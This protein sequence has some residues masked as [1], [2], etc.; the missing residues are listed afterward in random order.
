LVLSKFLVVCKVYGLKKLWF[1]KHTYRVF[2]SVV[3]IA[4]QSVFLLEKV[5]K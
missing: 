2:E 1:R 4:I 5:S 3:V